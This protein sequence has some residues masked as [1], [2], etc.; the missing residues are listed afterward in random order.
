MP[1]SPDPPERIVVVG[2]SHRSS[3]MSFRDRLALDEAALPRVLE[4]LRKTGCGEALVMATPER[5]EV[6]ALHARAGEAVDAIRGVLMER[7]GL[8]AGDPAA[9]FYAFR[10]AEAVRHLFHVAAGMESVV[11]GDPQAAAD[12]GAAREMS[13]RQGTLGP[14]LESL[15]GDAIEAASR[16]GADTGLA[17]RPATIAAAAV[18]LARD[19]HGDLSRAEALVLG[20]GE[21]G[22]LLVEALIAAGLGKAVLTG[23][24]AT[25][26]ERM[27]RRLKCPLVP[28]DALDAAL[29]AADIV[30]ASQGSSPPAL[31]AARMEAVLKRRRR[32]PVLLVDAAIPGDVERQ[33][34][35]LDGAFLYDM[36][37]LERFVME[38]G[39]ARLEAA[40]HAAELADQAAKTWLDRFE[41]GEGG[42]RD[43]GLR[44]R[45]EELR[46]VALQE[47]GDA[48]AATRL[49]IERLAAEIKGRG[50]GGGEG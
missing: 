43:K 15:V 38:R 28:F 9:R 1:A 48:A 29:E 2:T 30:I 39:V 4:R 16:I 17:A 40:K 24:S 34:N 22:E 7:A 45:L 19:I 47:T 18:E 3:T 36:G 20:P 35:D 6:L 44:Q 31:S 23:R 12:L 10:G 33:V 13:R 42:E 8:E 26:L 11:P 46:R 32:R 25:R 41:A 21:M 37:D 27:A 49:L 5:V 50:R 14:T